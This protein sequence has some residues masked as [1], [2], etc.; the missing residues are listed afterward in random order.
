MTES[1]WLA[2][3]RTVKFYVYHF[4]ATPFELYPDPGGF[5]VARSTV[6]PLRCEAVGDL[7]E[8]HIESWNR[9]EIYSLSLVLAVRSGRL[10]PALRHGQT[11]QRPHHF[12][13]HVTNYVTKRP[14]APGTLSGCTG[15]LNNPR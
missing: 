5:W 13:Y 9:A 14:Q 4:E 1:G 15:T 8:R 7:L 6:A 3:I 11:P 10:E 2:R 12:R